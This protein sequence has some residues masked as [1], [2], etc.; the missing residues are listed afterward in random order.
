MDD[1]TGKVALVTGA[2]RGLGR[3]AAIALAGA[4]VDVAINYRTREEEATTALA[5]IV[6]AG[7]RGVIVRA[8]VS[9]SGEV[10]EMMETV[11]RELGSVDILVNNAGIIR[12]QAIV[13]IR[14]E[15]WDELIAVNLKSAFLCTQA[16]LPA[17]RA[18]RWGRI[19]NMASVA[20][21]IGGLIGPHYSASKAGLVGLTHSYA[22]RL[23]KEGI[24][25]NAIHP[26]LVETDMVRANPQITPERVPIGRFGTPEECAGVVVLL[27]R[28]GYMT[29]QTIGLNGGMYFT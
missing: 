17:M 16:V 20:A 3:A 7:R 5:E 24:T 10:A 15:D 29:G 6:R 9:R 1:I 27:A 8:D 28:N 4:G 25:V 23:C 22:S 21:D 18:R 19:I 11:G 2:S 14:E 12:P 26:E 13:E